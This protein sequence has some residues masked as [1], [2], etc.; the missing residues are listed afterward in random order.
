MGNISSWV[1][2]VSSEIPGVPKTT[3]ESKLRSVIRSFCE[4]TLLYVRKLDP[5]SIV[6]NQPEYTL[7]PPAN[8]AIIMVEHVMFKSQPIFPESMDTLD[9]GTDNWR[10]QTSSGQT[11]YLT[12]VEKTLR[13]RD[14]PTE[15]ASSALS[16]WVALKP[17]A[18][19]DTVPDFIVED[20]YE[21]ILDA[22]KASLFKMTGKPWTNPEAGE[23]YATEY[24][25]HRSKA[26]KRKYTGLTKLRTKIMDAP[27]SN[28]G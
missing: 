28:M 12:D 19:T 2:D 14:I 22:C 4:S 26:K 16:V 5:I 25:E 11:E 23:Y 21:A 1:N 27:F 20:Y 24:H 15:N 17:S 18:T 9:R 13:L 10:D 7:T 3:I 8:T 6:A